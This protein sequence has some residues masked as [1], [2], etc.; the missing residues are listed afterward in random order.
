[1]IKRVLVIDDDSVDRRAVARALVEMGA[2][3]ELHEARD[4][5]HGIERVRNEQFDCILVDYNLPDMNGLDLLGELH[6]HVGFAV[7]VVMLTGNGSESIAVEAMKRGAQDY[8]PK[9]QLGPDA[10]ARVI[11]SAIEKC[12]LQKKLDEAQQ[13][14]ERLA[15]YDS[16]TGLG[17]RN[18]FH[19]E[20][21]R[22]VAVARRK[23]M[24][25]VVLMMDLDRFKAVNDTFGHEAGDAILA[26]VGGRLRSMARAA[27]AYF[28]LGGDEFT[29]V[30]D[31]GTDGKAVAQRIRAIVAEPITFEGNV[32]IVEISIG[33]ADY[34]ID[35]H[36]VGDLYRAADGAMYA[37]KKGKQPPLAN[38]AAA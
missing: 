25:F 23:S 28:R 21:A 29:A 11:A 10:L 7:P 3:Y 2:G 8:L 6:S 16:L 31:A 1:M 12:D 34:P 24:S 17:N 33:V 13:K 4:G 19:I 36:D 37:A 15:L 38:V 20:L 9:S 26:A 22:A 35:G 30:L 14:L 18:L 5:R 27:D 32:F